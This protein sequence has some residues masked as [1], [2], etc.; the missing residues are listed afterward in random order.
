M[1]RTF[2][3]HAALAIGILSAGAASALLAGQLAYT[4]S[5]CQGPA[6]RAGEIIAVDSAGNA[7]APATGAPGTVSERCTAGTWSAYAFAPAGLLSPGQVT[8]VTRPAP[9][10]Q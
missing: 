9:A 4:P 5:A 10:G 2:R 8:M 6:G 3:R 1:S 7:S